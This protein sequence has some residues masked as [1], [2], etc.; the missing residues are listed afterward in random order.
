MPQNCEK[1]TNASWVFFFRIDEWVVAG[2][3]NIFQTINVDEHG[4]QFRLQCVQPICEHSKPLTMLV[5]IKVNLN[6]LFKSLTSKRVNLPVVSPPSGSHYSN[7]RVVSAICP[8]APGGQHLEGFNY[9]TLGT[10]DE[11]NRP[12]I[13]AAVCVELL[14]KTWQCTSALSVT[15]SPT[16]TFKLSLFFSQSP[17][18][19]RS[20]MRICVVYPI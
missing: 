15:L 13:Q 18:L 5:M 12:H 6:M 7:C 14:L 17:C 9:V 11:S 16:K 1:N 10:V 20:S 3:A 4:E 2:N 8:N 19:F